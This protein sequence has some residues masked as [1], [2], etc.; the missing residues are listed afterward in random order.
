M[1]DGIRFF[2]LKNFLFR[3]AV[4]GEKEVN[5]KRLNLIE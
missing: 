2:H 1:E 5:K 3:R 4:L